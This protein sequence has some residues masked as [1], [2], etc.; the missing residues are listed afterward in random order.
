MIDWFV[1]W[2]QE[3]FTGYNIL[4][5]NFGNHGLPCLHR[6]YRAFAGGMKRWQV[7]LQQ[8]VSDVFFNILDK[9]RQNR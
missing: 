5:G 1:Q 8:T 6:Y 9:S 4:V 7:L 2:K 3:N